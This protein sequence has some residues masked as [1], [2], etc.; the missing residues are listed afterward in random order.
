M[1]SKLLQS[2]SDSCWAKKKHNPWSGGVF[3]ESVWKNAIMRGNGHYTWFIWSCACPGCP[4]EIAIRYDTMAASINAIARQSQE[5]RPQV[6]LPHW[7]RCHWGNWLDAV[8]RF[9]GIYRYDWEEPLQ[10]R[11]CST[12][13]K[14]KIRRLKP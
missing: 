8:G 7:I 2:H 4:A 5:S 13:G 1:K 10:V 12:C 3:R 9:G 6:K 11:I 14:R